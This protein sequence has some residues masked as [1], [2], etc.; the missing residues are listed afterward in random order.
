MSESSTR[1]HSRAEQ[2]RQ[3]RTGKPTEKTQ[4]TSQTLRRAGQ[5][6]QIPQNQRVVTR[7]GVIGTPT[8]R[9]VPT[10]TRR[11]YYVAL[12]TPGAEVRLP[13]MPLFR[14]SFRMISAAATFFLAVV[15]LAMYNAPFF[16]VE[17]AR[18]VGASR[19]TAE[20]INNTLDIS[21]VNAITL[22]PA[23]MEQDLKAAYPELSEV[24][25]K[26]GLPANVT[27]NVKERQPVVAWQQDGQTQWIDQSGVIFPARGEAPT[28]LVTIQATGAPPQSTPADAAAAG[29]DTANPKTVETTGAPAVFISQDL[30]RAI[31]TL[32]TQ[33]PEG[34][35][36]VYNPDY[37]LGWNDPRGWDVY[38][39]YSP[40]RMEQ[41]LSEYNIIVDKLTKDGVKPTMISVEYAQA[42]FYR[43]E[44]AAADSEQP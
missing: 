43:A 20:D 38:F 23:T 2:L 35:P 11:Q 13:T 18:L 7:A 42:P 27:V 31:S 25:V 30:L 36:I 22:V 32:G 39:G 41:K 14:P 16:K 12:S 44:K 33:A 6:A 9:P 19:L 29:S 21:G 34:V 5:A 37:G 8:R 17:N 24:H 40:D 15:I 3:R 1:S 4:F 28:A 26:V 10:Q